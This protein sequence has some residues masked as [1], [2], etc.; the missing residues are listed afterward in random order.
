M[1]FSKTSITIAGIASATVAAAVAALIKVKHNREKA[2]R[3]ILSD[4]DNYTICKTKPVV[5]F[6]STNKNNNS[7]NEKLISLAKNLSEH[8]KSIYTA[9]IFDN[10]D[11]EG[12]NGEDTL[13]LTCSCGILYSGF[14]DIT[15]QQMFNILNGLSKFCT[16][17]QVFIVAHSEFS[18]WAQSCINGITS[19]TRAEQDLDLLPIH[20]SIDGY[21]TLNSEPDENGENT[22]KICPVEFFNNDIDLLTETET[23]EYYSQLIKNS[24]ESRGLLD[25]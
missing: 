1:K 14:S 16:L 10:A 19:R 17:K 18:L 12:Y 24:L 8:T 21:I 3:N 11:I 9:N 23:V 15:K 20:D 22:Y 2:T 7:T 6:L 4:L 5:L 25:K 13:I